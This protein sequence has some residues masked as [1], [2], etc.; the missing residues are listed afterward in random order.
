MKE[1]NLNLSNLQLDCKTIYVISLSGVIIC[2]ILYREISSPFHSN[3][4]RNIKCKN[5]VYKIKLL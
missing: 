5:K 3:H 2:Y 1:L 4:R